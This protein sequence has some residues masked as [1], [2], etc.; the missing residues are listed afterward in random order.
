MTLPSALRRVLILLPVCLLL[1]GCDGFWGDGDD[2]KN[3][4][5]TEAQAKK[6]QQDYAGAIALLEKALEA[7]PHL[8]RAHWE[9]GLIYY[10]STPEVQDAAAA[11]YHF[12][13]LLQIAPDWKQAESVTNLINTCKL[14]LAKTAPLG[15]PT[16]ASERLVAQL[17]ASLQKVTASAQKLAAEKQQLQDVLAR[18]QVQWQ[19]A[20]AENAQL[21]ALVQRLQTPPA[22]VPQ[23]GAP[24][25]APPVR[26]APAGNLAPLA[27]TPARGQ[28]IN[29]AP[30]PRVMPAPAPRLY[31]VKTGDSLSSIARAHGVKLADLMAANPG[32]EPRRLK[33]GA[34]LK[35]P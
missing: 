16:T 19:Q 7:N 10:Q 6:N 35:L 15:P 2:A 34:E 13:K 21:R 17:T 18:T 5:L 24:T 1:A 22:P 14:E 28:G 27:A 12:R 11:I 31:R 3:A 4:L 9:L 26:P 25:N 8:A 23:A 20:A 32:V 30:P 29:P 33:V